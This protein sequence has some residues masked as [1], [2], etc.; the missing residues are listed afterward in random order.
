MAVAGHEVRQMI[1]S[2]LSTCGAKQSWAALTTIQCGAVLQTAQRLKR[3][4]NLIEFSVFARV[5]LDKVCGAPKFPSPPKRNQT[6]PIGSHRI[7]EK[8]I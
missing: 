1:N 6:G 7:G 2:I 8:E 5:N 4:L 3:V